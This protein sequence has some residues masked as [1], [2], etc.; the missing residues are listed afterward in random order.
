MSSIFDF[1][2]GTITKSWGYAS[3]WAFNGMVGGFAIGVITMLM[4]GNAAGLVLGPMIGSVLGLVGGVTWG[5][6]FGGMEAVSEGQDTKRAVER[7]EQELEQ[8]KTASLPEHVLAKAES[9]ASGVISSD[10]KEDK[11]L[12]FAHVETN[13]GMVR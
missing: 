5:T 1:F 11:P 3:S 10:A 9:V 13:R 6:L 7:A 8:E 2:R 12:V 4:T